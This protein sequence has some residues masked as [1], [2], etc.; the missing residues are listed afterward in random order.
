MLNTSLIFKSP[1]CTSVLWPPA[2][3]DSGVLLA[4]IILETL[5]FVLAQM[6]RLYNLG[7]KVS[8]PYTIYVEINKQ[9]KRYINHTSYQITSQDKHTN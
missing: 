5:G 8:K 4:L 1:I 2:V 9:S 6:H 3:T 7:I